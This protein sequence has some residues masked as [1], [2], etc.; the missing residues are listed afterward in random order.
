MEKERLFLSYN[1][2]DGNVYADELESQ[3]S[4]HFD[5]RRDKTQLIANDDI[6]DFM[7]D[8]ANCENVII[9]LTEEYVKSLNCMLEMSFLVMQP[10]WKMKAMVLVIDDSLYSTSRKMEIIS[11]W[12]LQQAKLNSQLGTLDDGK[13]IL[14]EE[15]GYVDSICNQVEQFLKGISR[16][17]NPSQI[18]IVSEIIKK[19]EANKTAKKD[20]VRTG[21]KYVIKFLAENGNL[22]ISQLSEK[23][24]TSP[25]ATHRMVKS[26]VEQGQIEKKVAG[27]FVTYA[28]KE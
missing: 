6:Y 1:W 17:K 22:T 14:E 12:R 10:D 5:V 27:R 21:E 3:L 4:S 28:V 8:I 24:G 9:I 16:R 15:K 25:A 2:K 7:A 26:L 20:I 11:Y 18:A 19:S 13:T 23:T